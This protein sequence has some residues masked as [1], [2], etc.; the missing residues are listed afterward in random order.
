MEEEIT[1]SSKLLLW[2]RLPARTRSSRQLWGRADTER[3]G[4]S[5]AP[6]DFFFS[7]Q[8]QTS[9]SLFSPA[10]FPVEAKEKLTA[11]LTGN[12]NAPGTE[13]A[14]FMGGEEA[15]IHQSQRCLLV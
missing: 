3:E 6:Y 12:E 5:E 8:L 11:S 10:A 9:K 2:Q 4:F 14:A 1:D 15:T 13:Q 7:A